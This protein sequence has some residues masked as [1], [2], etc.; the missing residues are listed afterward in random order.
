[1]VKTNQTTI[2][3]Q[4]L[5]EKI[6]SGVYSPAESLP[7]V[8]LATEYGVSRNTVKKALL[9]LESDAYVTIEQN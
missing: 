4:R 5:K 1:M 6:E 3:Y 7:E 2:V 8:E 9:M